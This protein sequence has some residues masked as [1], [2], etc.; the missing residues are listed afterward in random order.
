[1]WCYSQGRS[2]PEDEP[3]VVVECRWKEDEGCSK[4]GVGPVNIG[5]GTDGDG[6]GEL[7]VPR[8]WTGYIASTTKIQKM[9]FGV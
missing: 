3:P 8:V 7:V 5:I 1:M 4:G 2:Q 9:I 6:G